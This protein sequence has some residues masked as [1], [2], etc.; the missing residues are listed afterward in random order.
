MKTALICDR[1]SSV[2]EALQR[3][4]P[5]WGIG[6]FLLCDRRDDARQL[7]LDHTPDLLLLEA[8]L[9]VAGLELA[10]E[11]TD[12]VTAAV[13]LLMEP[14]GSQLVKKAVEAPAAAF[15]TKPFSEAALYYALIT[16]QRLAGLSD[17][18]ARARTG[19]AQRKDIERAKGLVMT[20][21]GLS[22]EQAYRR[23]RS[24]A[25]SRRISLA[26]LARELLGQLP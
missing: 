13:I 6:R 24:Q 15:L 8:A 23:M 3:V 16:A 11:L 19:L 17:E 14:E 7:A 2:L 22:E 18:L 5:Q 1:D 20:R 9:P 4:M 21:E 25:M 10:R 26:R 12:A